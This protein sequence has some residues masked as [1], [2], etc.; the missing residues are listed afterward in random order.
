MWGTLR[1]V[2]AR[3]LVGLSGSFTSHSKSARRLRH[4]T[5]SCEPREIHNLQCWRAR[6]KSPHAYLCA[7]GIEPGAAAWQ[8][9]T[10]P[11]ALLQPSGTSYVIGCCILKAS[12]WFVS[13]PWCPWQHYPPTQCGLFLFPPCWFDYRNC[14]KQVAQSPR[15]HMSRSQPPQCSARCGAQL[16]ITCCTCHG[17]RNATVQPHADIP[18][19][20]CKCPVVSWS[21]TNHRMMECLAA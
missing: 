17:Q 3:E 4:F 21:W 15:Q 16:A 6:N 8:A 2:T 9:H 10:L 7:P 11:L 1:V 13:L 12:M 18:S 19:E 5:W 20:Q 14:Q